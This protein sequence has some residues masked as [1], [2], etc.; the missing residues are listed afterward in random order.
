MKFDGCTNSQ[1]LRTEVS[2]KV[3]VPKGVNR[4]DDAAAREHEETSGSYTF[5]RR[6]RV[7]QVL[8]SEDAV[9]IGGYDSLKDEAIP[10]KLKANQ[11]LRL[12]KIAGIKA[13]DKFHVVYVAN[14]GKPDGVLRIADNV[15]LSGTFAFA[16]AKRDPEPSCVNCD[17]SEDGRCKVNVKWIDDYVSNWKRA[18]TKIDFD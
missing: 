5:V 11:I 9:L 2:E 3:K 17:V 8:N 14:N 4:A 1:A 13:R 12:T 18:G 16:G 7:L 15:A 10:L 6:D